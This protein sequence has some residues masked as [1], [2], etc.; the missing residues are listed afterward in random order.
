MR[1]PVSDRQR[2][3]AAAHADLAAAFLARRCRCGAQ[4]DCVVVGFDRVVEAGIV[5][6]RSMLDRNCCLA[7]MHRIVAPDGRVLRSEMRDGK[8]RIGSGLTRGG[9]VTG[10]PLAYQGMP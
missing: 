10:P 4:A 6:R 9:S 1:A 7:C 8:P 2:D 5:L 3:L